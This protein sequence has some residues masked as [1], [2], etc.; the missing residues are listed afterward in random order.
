M[1]NRYGTS[2]KAIN[3]PV[4]VASITYQGAGSPFKADLGTKRIR[5]LLNWAESS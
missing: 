3:S 1:P 4:S 5:V 2:A